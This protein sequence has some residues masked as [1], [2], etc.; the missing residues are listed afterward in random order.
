MDF[1]LRKVSCR[2]THPEPHTHT[3]D[4][5]GALRSLTVKLGIGCSEGGQSR[6]A[7]DWMWMRRRLES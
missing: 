6:Q 1:A 3:H 7:V 4:F 2:K 5:W